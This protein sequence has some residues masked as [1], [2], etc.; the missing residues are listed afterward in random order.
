MSPGTR[1]AAGTVA[2][3][4]SRT[5][6]ASEAAIFLS[7]AIAFSARYSWLNPRAALRTTMTMMAIVSAASPSAPAS[8]AAAISTTIMKSLNWS[9][10][11]A[12]SV[13]L[14]FSTSSFGPWA[15]S[16]VRGLGGAQPP[17]PGAERREAPHRRRQRAK[18]GQ[19]YFPACASLLT[20]SL[21]PWKIDLSP[22]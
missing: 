6:A 5:T 15:A 20:R 10:N 16:R 2:G 9:R 19:I 11:I 12:S 13:R 21:T 4:P 8:T 3:F 14:L 17:G 1:S 18:W 7:A 22:L